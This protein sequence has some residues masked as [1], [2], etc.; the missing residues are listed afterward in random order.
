MANI[1]M[2][3]NTGV[4]GLNAAQVQINT[5]GHNIT[6]A[7]SQHYTRQRVVQSA[8]MPMNTIPGGIGTGTQV[9]TVTRIH[10]EFT[11]SRLKLASSN[12]QSTE[13]KQNI[14]Q[15]VAQNFPDLEDASIYKD[16]TNYFKAWN[17]FSAN[18]DDGPQKLNLINA[19]NVLTRNISTT[20]AR[21]ENL[22][23]EVDKMIEINI[24]EVN[25]LA[26][27]I[28]TIN[29]EIN[30]VE[31]G[32]DAGIKINAN[33]LRDK[34]DELELAMSKLLNVNS[35]K[36]QIS[37]NM[38]VDSGITDEGRSYY[39]NIGGVSIVD[40]VNFHPLTITK[41]DNGT[42]SEIYYERQDGRRIDMA[43]KIYNGKIGAAL[44]LRGRHYSPNDAKF[45]DGVIQ[46]YIDNVNTFSRTLVHN[47]NNIYAKSA[48]EI[49]NTD[50]LS[51]LEKEK[52]LMNF[53]NEIQQGSFD[54]VVYNNQG[55]EVARKTININGTTTMDDTTY[56]NSI[57]EDFNSNSDDNHDNNMSNDV[58]DFFSASY[59]YDK[60]SNMGTFS[61]TPKQTQGIYSFSI[62]DNGTNFPG[63]I[64]INK[65]FSGEKASNI[66]VNDQLVA[67]PT[68]LR[69]YSKPVSGNNVVANDMVQL[70]YRSVNFYSNGMSLEKTETMEGYYRYL[71]TD[72]AS[73]AESNNTIH[74][75]NTSLHRTAEGEFESISG[76]N[77]NEELTNLIRFQSSYGAAA[78]IITT[79]DQMLDTLLSLKN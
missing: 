20:G 4:T 75:T 33:D 48:M 45:T 26:K 42:F 14:L 37:S 77:T 9:D 38:P 15:E 16:M 39:L 71:T 58:N 8:A 40:G 41:N 53:S 31:S 23:E 49:A 55:Q 67:D 2:S 1:F 43:D 22:Q 70:Q 29:K 47:T 17:D 24:N 50:E 28:A 30:R 57:V 59:Y 36:S 73:D 46:K 63:V 35:F 56:G 78:K 27:E 64:G 11:Y 54:V 21:L 74:E 69:A 5:T 60:T 52:T 72:I 65:V 68:K 62:I 7:D 34:R 66:K 10:D 6:N 79:V 12:L 61:V 76:V 13:Y 3:L 51:Y 25:K 18:P 19:A 44:D 32:K